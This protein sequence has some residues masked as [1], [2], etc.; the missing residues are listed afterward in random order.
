MFTNFVS[1]LNKSTFRADSCVY[2]VNFYQNSWDCTLYI[3]F[4]SC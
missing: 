3:C 2:C 1:Q 4:L